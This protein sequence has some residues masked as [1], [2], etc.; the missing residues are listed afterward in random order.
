MTKWWDGW[1]GMCHRERQLS[2]PATMLCAFHPWVT[3]RGAGWQ[4]PALM[5]KSD[6][7]T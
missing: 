1:V 5:A 7:S 2:S 3:G 6:A 4:P